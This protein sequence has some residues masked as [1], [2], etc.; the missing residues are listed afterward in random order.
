MASESTTAV[1]LAL[2]VSEAVGSSADLNEIL[3]SLRRTSEN[4]GTAM[5]K[6][7]KP[8]QSSLKGIHTTVQSVNKTLSELA[9][10]LTEVKTMT[11]TTQDSGGSSIG[12]RKAMTVCWDS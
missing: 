11:E 9:G 8:M 4:L 6:V 1:E 3:D 12:F 10:K 2:D 7:F 5:S